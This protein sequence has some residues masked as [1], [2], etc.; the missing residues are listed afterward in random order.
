MRNW[1]FGAV[2]AA[3]LAAPSVGVVAWESGPGAEARGAI[4]RVLHGNL[5]TAHAALGGMHATFGDH[6]MM[7]RIDPN[8]LDVPPP[9]EGPNPYVFADLGEREALRAQVE[10]ASEV[11]RSRDAMAEEIRAEVRQEVC[12]EM[13]RAA[14][15]RAEAARTAAE[16]QVHAEIAR[17]MAAEARAA[18]HEAVERARAREAERAMGGR[19]VAL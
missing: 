14:E 19:A 5:K 17:E 4:A 12:K 7:A 1:M 8:A 11:R 9:P 16:A 3:A 2:L 18:A 15:A 10:A 13:A 6:S